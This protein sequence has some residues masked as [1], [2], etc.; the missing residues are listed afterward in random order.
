MN[1]HHGQKIGKES[2]THEGKKSS[3]DMGP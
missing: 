1:S 3:D 2:T